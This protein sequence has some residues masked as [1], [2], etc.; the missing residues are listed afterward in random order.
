MV[1]LID[2]STP[3]TEVIFRVKWSVN[4]QWMIF[5]SLVMLLVSK[6]VKSRWWVSSESLVVVINAEKAFIT[7]FMQSIQ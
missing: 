1:T 6:T 5:V 3:R 7:V 2:V 4:R